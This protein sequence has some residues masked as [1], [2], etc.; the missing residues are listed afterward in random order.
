MATPRF[1]WGIDIGN[2]ALKAIKLVRDGDNY[3]VDRLRS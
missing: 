1:A 2:R 3:R